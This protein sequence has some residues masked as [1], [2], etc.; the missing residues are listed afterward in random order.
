MASLLYCLWCHYLHIDPNTQFDQYPL[1]TFSDEMDV[2][3]KIASSL[4]VCYKEL[5]IA[6]RVL[7][8]LNFLW[9][10]VYCSIIVCILFFGM[11]RSWKLFNLQ[12][13]I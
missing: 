13:V 12:T 7:L 2:Q 3:K 1:S 4:I 6:T 8:P 5:K 11:S 9:R 10:Y